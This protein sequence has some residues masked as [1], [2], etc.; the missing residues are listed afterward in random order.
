MVDEGPCVYTCGSEETGQVEHVCVQTCDMWAVYLMCG[1]AEVTCVCIS[2]S[3]WVTY[4]YVSRSAHTGR[5]YMY[6]LP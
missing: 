5:G 1:S 4:F 2:A 3:E 6:T